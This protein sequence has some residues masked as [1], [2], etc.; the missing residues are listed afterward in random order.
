MAYAKVQDSNRDFLKAAEGYYNTSNLQGVTDEQVFELL[1][2]A[3]KCTT[4]APSGPRKARLLATLYNEDR[5]RSNQFFDLLAKMFV[6]EVIRQE[7]VLEFKNKLEEHQNIV[8]SDG[9]SV[10][11]KALIE[12][13]IVVISRIY[14]N[15]RF[16][17]LGNFLGIKSEQA[18]EFIAKMVGEGRIQAVLD[19]ANELVE[20]EEEGRQQAT[21]ND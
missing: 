7:H 21:F 14:M 1:D 17:E 10:L 15:I 8:M 2:C 3:L 12:H 13:N 20:F 19:Q 9:Y 6:G 11:E 16:T 4:L 18:E 5:L